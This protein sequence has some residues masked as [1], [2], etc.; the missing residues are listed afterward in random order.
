MGAT[1]SFTPL[2]KVVTLSKSHFLLSTIHLALLIGIVR[3]GD[4]TWLGDQAVTLEFDNIFKK[5]TK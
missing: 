5:H 4:L 1:G 3:T 2:S